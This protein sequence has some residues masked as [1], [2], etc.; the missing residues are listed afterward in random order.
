MLIVLRSTA[1]SVAGRFQIAVYGPLPLQVKVAYTGNPKTK[2]KKSHP[3]RCLRHPSPTQPMLSPGELLSNS[4]RQ[5]E[6]ELN[7]PTP[8]HSLLANNNADI[9]RA[10][11]DVQSID[12]QHDS[13]QQLPVRPPW[14]HV[15]EGYGFRPPSG[16]STPITNG[17]ERGSPLPDPNGLGWPGTARFLSTWSS[18]A[19]HALQPSL[20]SLVSMP[21]HKNVPLARSGWLPRFA[22]S[23]NVLAKILTEKVS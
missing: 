7:H 6:L 4:L 3:A 9:P 14:P 2:K 5:L 13:S 11:A 18:H 8:S 15:R 10:D 16:A 21:R 22:P 1:R 17:A 12:F 23:W 20:P 19:E